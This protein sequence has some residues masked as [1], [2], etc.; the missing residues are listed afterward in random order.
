MMIHGLSCDILQFAGLAFILIGL[1]KKLKIGNAG[2][3]LISLAMSVAGTV[4]VWAACIAS[5]VWAL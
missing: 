1:L 3:L 5:F 4:L 2:M